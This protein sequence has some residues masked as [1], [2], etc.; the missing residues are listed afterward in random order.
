VDRFFDE[1]LV[2]AEDPAVRTNRLALLERLASLFL[3]IAD[4]SQILPE[5]AA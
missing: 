3:G 2:M 4:I 1:V 5:Q